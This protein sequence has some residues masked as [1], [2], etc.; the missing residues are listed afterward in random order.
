MLE[1]VTNSCV[2]IFLVAYILVALEEKLHLKKTVPVLLSACVIWAFIAMVRHLLPTSVNSEL[3]HN[4]EEYTEIFLFILVAMTY[5]NALTELGLFKKIQQILVNKRLS[6]K[7][8][9]WLTGLITFF[10]SPIA[11]N[12]TAA[13]I[14]CAVVMNVAPEHKKFVSLSCINIV[15]ASNA[16]GA[17]SPFGDITTLMVWQKGILG[18][19]DFFKIFIPSFINYFVPAFCMSFAIKNEKTN[20]TQKNVN[21]GIPGIVVSI[22]FMLTILT[23]V[24]FE[25][26]LHL[27]AVMGMLLGLGYLFI[28]QYFLE[29]SMSKHNFNIFLMVSKCEWDTLL[30]L[31]GICLS[32]GGLQTL[33]VLGKI[34]TLLYGGDLMLFHSVTT[35]AN[36][37]V[38]LA[39]AV[40]DN[41]PMM[42]SVLLVNPSM[43]QADW[44]LATLTIGC[45][46]S[47]LSIGSGAGVALMGQSRGIYTFMSHIKWS[48][49]IMLG[50]FASIYAHILLN[51]Q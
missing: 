22:L 1:I 42:Y 21:L 17:F 49:A 35:S 9:F 11:D 28:Y 30:F 40:F 41:I 5:V 2:L 36:T 14:M 4:L 32:V 38:G 13:L 31:L 26:F 3:K 43:G 37:L 44:L 33:G 51:Y 27:P 48:W 46:G 7:A 10:I 24:L 8:L 15:V 25:H 18:F 12:I 20:P 23:A 39:S 29:V 19:F 45:G 50:Y 16:G 6:L 47:L 34:S